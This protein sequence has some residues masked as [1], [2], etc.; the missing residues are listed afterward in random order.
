VVQGVTSDGRPRRFPI[1]W[2][3]RGAGSALIVPAEV[4]IDR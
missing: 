1:K 2:R 4:A 3:G